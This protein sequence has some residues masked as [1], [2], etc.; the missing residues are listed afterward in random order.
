MV[1]E[2]KITLEDISLS[3]PSNL[4]GVHDA[5]TTRTLE[6]ISID[7]LYGEYMVTYTKNGPTTPE[8]MTQEVHQ[9]IQE[10]PIEPQVTKVKKVQIASYH[11][12]HH[13]ERQQFLG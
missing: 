11:H 9:T 4:K 12:P 13:L 2:K 10:S 8:D 6:V 7:T 3:K 1:Q 5:M